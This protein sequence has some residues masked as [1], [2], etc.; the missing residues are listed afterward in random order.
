M[1]D[2]TEKDNK[3]IQKVLVAMD[4]SRH[5]NAA[6]EAAAKLA[7]AMEANMHG[8]FVHDDR[9]YRV[10]RLP[11]MAEVNELTGE[12]EPLA[13]KKLE[14]QIR[15]MEY[16][17]QQRFEQISKRNQLSYQWKTVAGKVGE[18]LLEASDEA[19]LITI[20]V[21]GQSYTARKRLGRTAR[22]IIERSAK[23]VL[24]LQEGLKIGQSIIAINDGSEQSL[25]G[26][27]LALDLAE[28][29]DS[30]LLILKLNKNEELSQRE[31]KLE[32]TLKDSPVKAELHLLNEINMETLLNTVNRRS[33]GLLVIPKSKYFSN[34]RAFEKLLYNLSNPIL[35]MT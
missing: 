29:N 31:Q 34:I 23:P 32:N 30:R 10:C 2:E 3:L 28:K 21:K 8:L 24:I 6:L 33:G 18:K 9:W 27:E 15:V 11:S 19:D 14:E 7:K 25:A 1:P 20:G 26:I 35:L 4:S 17:I 22:T 12:I 13:V 5:S 16:R